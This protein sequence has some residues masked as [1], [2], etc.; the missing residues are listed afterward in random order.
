MRTKNFAIV[1]H[2]GGSGYVVRT[3]YELPDGTWWIPTPY[4]SANILKQY[5]RQADAER[6]AEKLNRICISPKRYREAE[7]A[8]L[9]KR[10]P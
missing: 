5:R 8:A 3:A 6:Y 10:V 2:S 4:V 1:E 9:E 7:T